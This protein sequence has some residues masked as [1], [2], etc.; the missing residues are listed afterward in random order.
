MECST[1]YTLPQTLSELLLS[2]KR[3]TDGHVLMQKYPQINVRI[4]DDLVKRI[5]EWRRC[6]EDLPNK[7]EAIR[8]LVELGLRVRASSSRKKYSGK[9]TWAQQSGAK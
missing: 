3:W 9:R 7:P 8:R 6:Q 4:H 5:D 1:Q 2:S